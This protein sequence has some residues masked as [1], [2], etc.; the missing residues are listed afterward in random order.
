[1]LASPSARRI[2]TRRYVRFQPELLVGS[3]FG[4]AV[5]V[6]MLM[7]DLWRSPCLLLAQAAGFYVPDPRL[8][9]GVRVMLVHAPQDAVVPCEQ[10]RALAKTG[11]RALVELVEVDDDHALTHLVES[12]ELIAYVK[13]AV[14]T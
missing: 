12:G 1:V 3:S 4:G 5:V 13:R 9:E 2:E 8:P 6:A 10:S 14:A 11:T 7:R